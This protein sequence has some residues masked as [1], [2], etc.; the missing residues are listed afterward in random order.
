[1]TKQ[2]SPLLRPENRKQLIEEAMQAISDKQ[3]EVIKQ[4]D[5]IIGDVEAFE[6]DVHEKFVTLFGKK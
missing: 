5:E 2:M 1:M 6:K 3:A 4:A